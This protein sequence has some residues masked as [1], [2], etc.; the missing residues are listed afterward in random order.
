MERIKSIANGIIIGR[1]NDCKTKSIGIKEVML[2]IAF[3]FK[4]KIKDILE[5][6]F[7]RIN[8]TPL[9]KKQTLILFDLFIHLTINFTILKLHLQVK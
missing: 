9:L 2:W 5:K 4:F 8:L 7:I 1:S 6:F 3:Y